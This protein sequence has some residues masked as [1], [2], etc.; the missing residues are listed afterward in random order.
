MSRSATGRISCGSPRAWSS[1]HDRTRETR[2]YGGRAGPPDCPGSPWLFGRGGDGNSVAV[3]P[4]DPR[5]AI[6]STRDGTYSTTDGGAGGTPSW[7]QSGNGL[8]SV[9]F[10]MFY[11]PNGQFVYAAGSDAAL[12]Q[13]SDNGNN[14]TRILLAPVSDLS[15]TPIDSNIIWVGLGNGI[16][17]RTANAKAGSRANWTFISIGGRPGTAVTGIAVDPANTS[18]AVAVFRPSGSSTRVAFRTVDNGASWT[19][20]SSNLRGV[21]LNAVVIDPNT[22]P[23]AIIVATDTGVQRSMDFGATWQPLGFA[24]PNVHCTSLAIDP[25][26]TPSLLRVGTYGRSVFELAYQRIYVD[27]NSTSA[28]QDGT[29]E[30]PFH[31]L[32]QG[33]NV[34]PSGA[35]RFV[36]IQSGD[37]AVGPI[38]VSQCATLNALNGVV[39]ID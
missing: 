33:L 5:H 6:V 20:I 23:H 1:R 27:G 19:D 14:F 13:S 17:G 10:L 8:P 28:T 34:P 38:T 16:V 7:G 39:R 29:L 4:L 21:P 26:A 18:Q 2:G 36:N 3:D 35:V 22:S 32:P 37:Y 12:Y 11:D 24:L 30:N 31:T 15:M 9:N 25:S